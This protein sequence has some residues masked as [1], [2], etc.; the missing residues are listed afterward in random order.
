MDP[1]LFHLDWGKTLEVLAT[2]VILAFMVERG[3]SVIFENEI[4]IKH[5]SD[6]A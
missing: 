5:F 1:N 6:K 3:L 2:N 4:F